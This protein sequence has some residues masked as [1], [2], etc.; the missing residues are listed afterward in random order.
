[1]NTLQANL[2]YLTNTL[3]HYYLIDLLEYAKFLKQKAEKETDTEYLKSI[4]GMVDSILSASKE[5][6]SDCEQMIEW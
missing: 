4:P 2:V 5:D 6:L 3:P 1:M